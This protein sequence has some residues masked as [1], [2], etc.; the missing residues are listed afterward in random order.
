MKINVIG[1][2]SILNYE[3]Y[4][5]SEQSANHNNKVNTEMLLVKCKVVRQCNKLV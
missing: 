5:T 3:L 4:H 1:L 2:V